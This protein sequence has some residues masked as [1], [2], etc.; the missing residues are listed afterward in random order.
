MHTPP[1]D[2]KKR[3]ALVETVRKLAEVPTIL[4]GSMGEAYEFF[5][6][7]EADLKAAEDDPELYTALMFV[8]TR[9]KQAMEVRS[10]EVG[11]ADDW[12]ESMKE[13]DTMLLLRP[14]FR[15]QNDPQ[16]YINTYGGLS[17]E[18][19]AALDYWEK[20][21]GILLPRPEVF[22]AELR[23]NSIRRGS[24]LILIPDPELNHIWFDRLKAVLLVLLLALGLAFAIRSYSRIAAVVLLALLVVVAATWTRDFISSIRKRRH[25]AR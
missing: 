14:L 3:E 10:R 15:A 6:Q 11:K 24:I 1:N 19:K 17:A 25:E 16:E 20:K 21:T 9:L 22:G 18:Q 5:K 12:A 4:M 23:W 13:H 2:R 7:L 8:R